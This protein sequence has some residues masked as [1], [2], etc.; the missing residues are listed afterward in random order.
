[1]FIEW[2]FHFLNPL[3]KIHFIM[4]WSFAMISYFLLVTLFPYQI[5][6]SYFHLIIS[7]KLFSSFLLVNYTFLKQITPPFLFSLW[8]LIAYF[9]HAQIVPFIVLIVGFFLSGADCFTRQKKLSLNLKLIA[10]FFRSTFLQLPILLLS[11]C[12]LLLLLQFYEG[13]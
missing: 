5:R 6:S 4:F 1:M 13:R 7:L 8:F 10:I 9:I 2:A 11:S 3:P 12:L